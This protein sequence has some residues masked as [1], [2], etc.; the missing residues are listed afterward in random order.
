MQSIAIRT[1]EKGE[2]DYEDLK[3]T[4]QWHRHQPAIILANIGTTM[5]EAK[6]DISKIQAILKRFAIRN[7]YIHCDAALAGTYLALLGTS[8]FDFNHGCDS[9]A[10]SGHKFIGSPIPCGV[11][12][13]KKH[14]KDRVGRAIP[15]IGTLDTT[16]SGSRNAIAP[17]F[18]WYAIQKFGKEGLLKRAEECLANAL[19]LTKELNNIGI[20]AWRNQDALTVVM[21]KPSPRI[22]L[23]WSLATDQ[24][25]AH[26]ICM[27]GITKEKLKLFIE[28]IKTDLQP[29]GYRNPVLN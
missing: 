1:N 2:M 6:D 25:I 28:D 10:I 7:S 21:P 17:L 19:F 22:C 14:Y 24:D 5:T 12:L 3:E 20:A 27:P 13:V 26:V 11:I 18:M 15:Y 9:I 8:N 23:K 29:S 4:I 16:I